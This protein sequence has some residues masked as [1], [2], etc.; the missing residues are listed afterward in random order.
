[1]LV[2]WG[3]RV[4]GNKWEKNNGTTNS[5]INKIYSQNYMY[6]HTTHTH[7][8]WKNNYH[9]TKKRFGLLNKHSLTGAVIFLVLYDIWFLITGRWL[10][11]NALVVRALEARPQ[12]SGAGSIS[13]FTFQGVDFC[14]AAICLLDWLWSFNIV[15]RFFVG[16][17]HFTEHGLM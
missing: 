9:H 4:E 17:L 15:N 8:Y 10:I 16:Y 2:G 13:L 5:I 12:P 1:M 14:S 3:C 11:L 6:I 7:T